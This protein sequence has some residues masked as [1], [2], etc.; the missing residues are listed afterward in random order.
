[1][2][3]KSKIDERIGA[4][5]AS[6]DPEESVA[7]PGRIPGIGN[8]APHL[9]DPEPAQ[10]N[11]NQGALAK[12]SRQKLLIPLGLT[13]VCLLTAVFVFT[14]FQTALTAPS[15]GQPGPVQPVSIPNTPNP[16]KIQDA[17]PPSVPGGLT[18][19]TDDASTVNLAWA[20]ASDD[21]G[22]VGYTIYRDGVSV[23]TAS[24]SDLAFHDMV[25]LPGTTYSYTLDAYDQA[26]N[27]SAISSPVQVT[28]PSQPGAQVFILPEEDTYI[29]AESPNSIYGTAKTLRIDASPD[30]HAYLRFVVTGLNGKTITRA[31]LMLYAESGATRGIQV[32]SVVGNVWNELGTNYF[33]APVLGSLLAASPPT[34]SDNW[35]ALDVTSYVTGEGR[36]NFGIVTDSTTGVHLASRETGADSPK[37]SLDLH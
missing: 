10:R 5:F 3:K 30:I 23:A 8:G 19:T 29:N 32:M 21:L 13:T 2:T 25:A 35:I 1:M 9:A 37:L 7:K 11:S 28:T 4:L 16:T 26:G 34:K 36:F 20:A 14:R 12:S 33:N 24:G 15:P 17:Q 27:H 18:V 22:V 31:R 6:L